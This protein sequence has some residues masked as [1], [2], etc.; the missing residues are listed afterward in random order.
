MEKKW[1][2]ITISVYHIVH[3]AELIDK[4]FLSFEKLISLDSF[5]ENRNEDVRKMIFMNIASQI[6]IYTNSLREEYYDHFNVSKVSTQIE[7][8][9]VEQVTEMLKPV[10]GTINKW[11]DIGEFRNNVLAHKLRIRKNGYKSVLTERGLSGYNIPEKAIDFAFLIRCT[12]LIKEVVYK[13][14]ENEYIEIDNRINSD[15][16][17]RIPAHSQR[18]YNTEYAELLNEMKVIQ[19]QIDTRFA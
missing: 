1:T 4:S 13:V 5:K 2:D 9:K 8:A 7:K 14:F 6:L 15:K 3:F 17:A 10:F 16:Y 12:N 11:N 18:D 19:K